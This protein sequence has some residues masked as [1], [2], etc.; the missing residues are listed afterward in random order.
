MT[1]PTDIYQQISRELL[2][3]FLWQ[4]QLSVVVFEEAVRRGQALGVPLPLRYRFECPSRSAA[5]GLK[6]YLLEQSEDSIEI[7]E[8]DGHWLLDATAP[9]V[10][11]DLGLILRWVGYLCD[12]GS[13]FDSR[14][15]G[16]TPPAPTPATAPPPAS[17]GPLTLPPDLADDPAAV[18]LARLWSARSRQFFV[19]NPR[20]LPDPAAWGIL[21]LDL[22]RHAARAYHQMDDRS[23]TDA[24]KR[25]LAGFMAEMKEPSDR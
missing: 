18:E 13:Q 22:M 2:E 25:I 7:G 15:D 24:Y 5:E 17:S 19:L 11:F 12:A 23:E 8:A 14:F 9:A 6:G 3:N 20:A 4:H 21:G 1:R 10:E 16:W